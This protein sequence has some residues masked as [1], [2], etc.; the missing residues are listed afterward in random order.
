MQSSLDQFRQS[1]RHEARDQLPRLH[2]GLE[3]PLAS[4]SALPLAR[5]QQA[6]TVTPR[7]TFDGA[8]PEPIRCYRLTESSIVVPRAFGCDYVAAHRDDSWR[9]AQLPPAEFVGSLKALQLTAF[10]QSCDALRRSPGA[11]ILTLPCGFGKTVV[12]LRIAHELNMRTLVVVHKEFL[13]NQW[14][15][16]ISQFL[17]ARKVTVLRGQK[18]ADPSADIVLAMLQT[19]NLR[20]PAQHPETLAAVQSCGLVV[21]DEAHH[22]AARS[23]SDLFFHLPVKAVLGLTATPKRKDGCTKILHHFMG[24]HSF[25]LEDTA[26]P[27]ERPVVRCLRFDHPRASA[28][29][30]TG[31]MVQRLKTELCKDPERNKLIVDLLLELAATGRQIIVL[32]DRVEH[33]KQL[34][35]HFQH[36]AA[37]VKASLFV[38]GQ[39]RDVRQHAEKHCSVLFATFALAKEGLDLP[40]L[41]TLVLATPSSD[42]TQAV[43]RILRPCAEKMAPL[44][45]DIQD[46]ACLQ[47]VR[48]NAARIRFYQ[49]NG[50]LSEGASS[51]DSTPRAEP[52]QSTEP[53]EPMEP[54]ETSGA[55]AVESSV[56]APKRARIELW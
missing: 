5:L 17:P 41:D 9:P 14:V 15:E 21:I 53:T 12:A 18:A 8:H 22:M 16:R 43:G 49:Q 52:T 33:L 37:E 45:V 51:L 24:K 3:I 55:P 19:L 25:C 38:G 34:L 27:R 54:A 39:R 28:R 1:R 50:I 30:L 7:A 47:F 4:I 29:Q 11:C 44:V 20:L 32:S 40:R 48:Q 46:D 23:F 42:I 6:L 26:A 36:A 35:Q 2:G 56:P 31:G 13:L 10:E